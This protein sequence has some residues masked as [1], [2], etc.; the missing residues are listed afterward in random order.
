MTTCCEANMA[1]SATSYNDIQPIQFCAN[2]LTATNYYY[3]YNHFTA[4]WIL[5]GTT[6]VSWYQKGKTN[7]D[8]SGFVH[9][10]YSPHHSV[11]TGR[12]PF[13]PPNQER[14]SNEGCWSGYMFGSR[15]RFAYGPAD[16]TATHYLLLQQIQT[17]FTFLVR[18]TQV[19]PD[20]IQT[21][22]K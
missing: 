19:D 18:F 2:K 8:Q 22:V 5:S 15:C 10:L 6:Q 11:F 3:Y 14:Q 1:T 17:G 4:L 16:A 12:M 13:L 20:K 7:L 21:A 9:I